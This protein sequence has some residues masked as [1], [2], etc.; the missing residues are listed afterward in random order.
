MG[1]LYNGHWEIS[2]GHPIVGTLKQKAEADKNGKAVKDHV[3]LLFEAA[4]LSLGFS[5]GDP[6]TYS[7]HI[8]CLI[9]LGFDIDEDEASV[10]SDESPPLRMMRMHFVWK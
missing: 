4:L 5:L 6:Q 8:C 1:Q 2:L 10:V 7:N 3:V 9:K